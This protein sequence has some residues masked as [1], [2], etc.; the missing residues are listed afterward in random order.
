MSK[1]NLPTELVRQ[2]ARESGATQAQ[3]RAVLLSTLDFLSD[4]EAPVVIRGFGVFKNKEFAERNRYVPTH[5]GLIR[6]PACQRL[7]FRSTNV[8]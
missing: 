5:K 3:T 6:L 4:A 7:V 2:V 1:F 8:K